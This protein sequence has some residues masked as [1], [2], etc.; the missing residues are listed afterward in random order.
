MEQLYTNVL[1]W[2]AQGCDG[3]KP[4]QFFID[5]ENLD[6]L[7]LEGLSKQRYDVTSDIISF[8]SKFTKYRLLNA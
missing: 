6:A 5:V 7:H 1:Y 2:D 8:V 3:E 4:F